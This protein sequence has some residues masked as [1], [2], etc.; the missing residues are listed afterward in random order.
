MPRRIASLGTHPSQILRPR[1]DVVWFALND[2]Q[3]V[4]AFAGIWTEFNGDRGTKSKPIP[5][6]HFVH[7]FLTTPPN[8]VVEPIHPKTMPVIRA[9]GSDPMPMA[10]DEFSRFIESEAKKWETVAAKAGKK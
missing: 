9:L 2:D 8:A 3:P 5:G 6:P 1:K 7:G 10:P 4:F